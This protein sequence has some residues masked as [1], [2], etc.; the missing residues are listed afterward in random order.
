MAKWFDPTDAGDPWKTYN[1]NYPTLSDMPTITQ[2]MGIWLRL[3]DN[4]GDYTITTGFTGDYS[5]SSIDITLYP[6]WNMVSYP[7]ATSRVAST[8]LPPVIADNMA[9]Y[10]GGET[11]LIMDD[12]TLATTLVEGNAYWVHVT[13]DVIWSVA[14]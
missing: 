11:Y 4:D 14:P 6:G 2:S 7:S 3:V 8:T 12:P 9:Y 5:G 10:D 1:T 13:A